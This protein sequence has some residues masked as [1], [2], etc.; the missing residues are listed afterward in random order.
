MKYLEKKG[1]DELLYSK[2]M[3]KE[4]FNN[5]IKD[6]EDYPEFKILGDRHFQRFFNK[7]YEFFIKI[8]LDNIISPLQIKKNKYEFD[9]YEIKEEEILNNKDKLFLNL[10]DSLVKYYK[11]NGIN[12]NFFKNYFNQLSE[13]LK[14]DVINFKG[15]LPV[16]VIEILNDIQF[17]VEIIKQLR[18]YLSTNLIGRASTYFEQ[19]KISYSEEDAFIIFN[20][21]IMNEETFKNS[22]FSKLVELNGKKGKKLRRPIG[23][24]YNCF[25]Y[26]P[27]LCQGQC[28]EAAKDNFNKICIFIQSRHNKYNP[29]DYPLKNIVE[30]YEECKSCCHY[31]DDNSNLINTIRDKLEEEINIM[32][33]RTCIFCHNK[34]EYLFHPLIYHTSKNKIYNNFKIELFQDDN[35]VPYDKKFLKIDFDEKFELRELYIPDNLDIQRIIRFL[36]KYNSKN[37]VLDRIMNLPDIKTKVCPLLSKEQILNHDYSKCPYYHN[38]LLERRRNLIIKYNDICPE[39]IIKVNVE[40]GKKIEWKTF[41]DLKDDNHKDDCEYYHN[42]NEVFFDRRNYRKIY[43][44]PYKY[45]VLGE[46][47]PYKHPSDI[48]INEIYL[49][50]KY[51]EEL[52]K[53]QQELIKLNYEISEK[54]KKMPKCIICRNVLGLK[55]VVCE[56]EH[57][58][59]DNC[60]IYCIN[61]CKVCHSTK[62]YIINLTKNQSLNLPKYLSVTNKTKRNRGNNV[63]YSMINETE[64]EY[65]DDNKSIDSNDSNIIN[66]SMLKKEKKENNHSHQTLNYNIDISMDNNEY[67]EM[68]M[69]DLGLAIPNINKE[70]EKEEDK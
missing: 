46:L 35:C 6:K 5:Y 50:E 55:F 52:R 21:K 23:S 8:E 34:N 17:K 18:F 12:Q 33:Y 15:S 60:Q 24:Q 47:C 28:K 45:C 19:N 31:L 62:N 29:N 37:S 3:T 53:K 67:Q 14:S 69:N 59:C 65:S 7:D 70:E 30:N 10:C 32:Y 39:K 1:A 36:E 48:K 63:L 43:N 20:Y 2:Y 9:P 64:E 41:K 13:K 66:N 38:K 61:N 27:I 68:T 22:S 58:F 26:L 42:R 44:C 25:N 51:R 57:P 4:N 11:T 56:N 40:K 16:S 49:P 54:L